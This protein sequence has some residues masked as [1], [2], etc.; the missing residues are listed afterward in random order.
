MRYNPTIVAL[1]AV[2]LAIDGAL[3]N[4]YYYFGE[5]VDQAQQAA[6]DGIQQAEQ[7]VAQP[8]GALPQRIQGHLGDLLSHSGSAVKN[9]A[10]SLRPDV[11]N[12]GK[13]ISEVYQVTRDNVNS[14]VVEPLSHTVRP[15]ID[16]AQ[17]VVAPYV[18]QAKE[19][20]PKLINQAGPALSKVGGQ[21]RDGLSEVWSRISSATSGVGNTAQQAVQGGV[22]QAAMGAQQVVGGGSQAMENGQQS[23][24][25]AIQQ[26]AEAIQKSVK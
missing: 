6:Q 10:E 2:L 9:V 18:N 13:D 20:V 4:P 22:N 5:A 12:I 23:A 19:E 17:K 21:V 15:Y 1:V 3:A 16:H 24:T 26:G 14:R 11:S 25:N 7:Q 8:G